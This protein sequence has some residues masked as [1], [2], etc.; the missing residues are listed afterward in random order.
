MLFQVDAPA[1]KG[2]LPQAVTDDMADWAGSMDGVHQLGLVE[3]GHK[4]LIALAG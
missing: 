4:N 2:A 1:L 3:Y